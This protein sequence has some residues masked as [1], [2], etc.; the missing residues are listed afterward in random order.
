MRV[1]S[2]KY[3]GG[4]HYRYEAEVV[5]RGDG[6]LVLY[7]PLGSPLDSYRGSFNA[8]REQLSLHWTDRAYSMDIVWRADFQPHCHYVNVATPS[9]WHDGV[10]RFVD[11]DLDVIW[12]AGSD[13]VLLDDEDEFEEHR[14]AFGYPDAL[15]ERARRTAAEVQALFATRTPPF[16]GSLYAWRP[17]RPLDL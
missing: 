1:H 15:V 8:R 11:L 14:L 17:G 6:L 4:L 16:D 12:P 2:T 9:T 10:V 3:D 7:R 13:Q 5:A